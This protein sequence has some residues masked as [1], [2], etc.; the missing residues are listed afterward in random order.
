MDYQ[1]AL[2]N[3]GQ[4]IAGMIGVMLIAAIGLW[5]L[6]VAECDRCQHCRA[7]RVK[8]HAEARP[9]LQ[10]NETADPYCPLHR[11]RRSTCQAQH[12]DEP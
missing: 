10:R 9:W 3:L 8:R 7:E 5:L 11:V 12:E 1:L 4:L 6:P 2:S